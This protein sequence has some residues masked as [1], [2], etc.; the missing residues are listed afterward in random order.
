MTQNDYLESVVEGLCKKFDKSYS[1][2]EIG[3]AQGTSAI[4]T[5]QAMKRAQAEHWFFTVDP[6]GDKPYRAGGSP[7]R[8]FHY[9]ERDYRE[10][11]QKMREFANEHGLNHYH[12]R[13][14]SEDFITV[15]PQIEFWY[16][17][18]KL[19]EK[20]A[21]VFLDGEHDWEPVLKELAWFYERVPSGGVIAIDDYNLLGKEEDVRMRLEGF[22]GELFFNTSDDH[23]RVYLTK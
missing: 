12:W 7:T 1:L 17:G 22:E 21:W 2:V 5:M 15:F 3:V 8:S 4:R 16:E 19:E 10:S 23:Y 6:H 14:R 20:F 13:L 9:D 18:G 11:Q